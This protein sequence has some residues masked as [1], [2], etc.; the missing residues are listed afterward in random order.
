M[1]DGL[2]GSGTAI[3]LTRQDF[4]FFKLIKPVVWC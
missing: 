2:G 1:M 4:E 3:D